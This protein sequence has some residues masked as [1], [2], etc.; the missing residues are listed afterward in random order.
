[1]RES[2]EAGTIDGYVAEDTELTSF[3]MMDSNITGIN[4]SK[5]KGFKVSS[6][7]AEVSIGVKKGNDQLLSQVNKVLAG[8]STSERS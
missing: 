8:I 2:L 3:Q 6:S 7:D 4:L 5:M 1:M